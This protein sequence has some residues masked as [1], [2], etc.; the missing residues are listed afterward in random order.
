MLLISDK[1]ELNSLNK[2]D[3]FFGGFN[4]NHDS[5]QSLLQK[6]LPLS[7]GY[8]LKLFIV[9]NGSKSFV[10]MSCFFKKFHKLGINII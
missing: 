7:N 9:V 2:C 5:F 3:R 10:V 6:I 1:T 8:S 4:A